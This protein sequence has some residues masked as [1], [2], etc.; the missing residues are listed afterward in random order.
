MRTD[1]YRCIPVV[2]FL[3]LALQ[4]LR[5][6]VDTLAGCPVVSRQVA[7]LPVRVNDVRVGRVCKRLMSVG[8][9]DKVPV[10]ITNA[11]VVI[12]SARAAKRRIDLCAYI[13]VVE[14]FVLVDGNIVELRNRLSLIHI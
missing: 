14:R 13:D 3:D 4:W 10:R 5:A 2:A 7:F 11:D 8:A 9:E 1:Q 12:R 6:D